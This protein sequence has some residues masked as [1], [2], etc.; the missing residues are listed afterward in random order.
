M[1][2]AA[3]LK[4]ASQ[5]LALAAAR[6]GLVWWRANSGGLALPNGRRVIGSPAGTPD[7]LV[8]LPPSGR[9]LG[10]EL[11]SPT[12]RQRPSQRAWQESA[13]K[14]GAGYAIVRSL[15][16]LR[17]ALRAEGLDAP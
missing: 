5:Y 6:T 10:L 16:E 14:A 9:L 12:G 13:E 15:E 11:K 2:E 1:T 4:A 3:L 7:L 8:V 17:L